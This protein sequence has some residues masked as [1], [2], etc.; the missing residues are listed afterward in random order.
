MPNKDRTILVYYILIGI[1]FA[2]IIFFIETDIESPGLIWVAPVAESLFITGSLVLVYLMLSRGL[3]ARENLS[4]AIGLSFL[5]TIIPTLAWLLTW[6]NVVGQ[7]FIPSTESTHLW[8]LY[9]RDFLFFV[10]LFV[11]LSMRDVVAKVRK[12]FISLLATSLIVSIFIATPP[13]LPD[14]VVK[15]QY[16]SLNRWVAILMLLICII[17]IGKILTIQRKTITPVL[18]GLILFLIIYAEGYISFIFADK[19]FDLTWL[20]GKIVNLFAFGVFLAILIKEY[21]HYFIDSFVARSIQESFKPDV[22]KLSWL[23]IDAQYRPAV[24]EAAIGG[25]WYDVLTLDGGKTLVLILGDAIG[26]GIKAITTMTEAKFLFRSYILDGLNIEEAL[27]KLNRY[28]FKYLRRDEF[29]TMAAVSLSEET[30]T[31]RYA[32]A[33]HPSPIIVKSNDWYEITP[34][35]TNL[36]LGISEQTAY[37]SFEA[38]LEKGS[39]LTIFSDGVPEARNNGGF[40]GEQNLGNFIYSNKEKDLNVINVSLLDS[41]QS[42]WR[43]VDDLTILIARRLI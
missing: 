19:R 2:L 27:T 18:T 3:L 26:K 16:L 35:Q 22:P 4:V 11:L 36:P 24:K 9:I 42:K 29:V 21:T 6:H 23:E 33:G 10:T 41:L 43:T 14:L 20:L 1:I 12:I 25:D 39:I 32:S 5:A 17:V 34:K 13:F 37:A 28:L 30:P 31:F 15:N 40:F 8:I 38:S 7:S